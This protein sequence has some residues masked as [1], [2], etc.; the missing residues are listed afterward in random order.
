MRF[1]PKYMSVAAALAALSLGL[2]SPA[3]AAPI[4]FGFDSD[5]TLNLDGGNDE[6]FEEVAA[7]DWKVGNALAL[8]GNTAIHTFLATGGAVKTPFDVFYQASLAA[9]LDENGDPL[10]TSVTTGLNQLTIVAGFTEQVRSFNGTPGTAGA[11][12]SFELAAAQNVNY[13]QIYWDDTTDASDLHG[14]GFNNTTDT[15]DGTALPPGSTV[16]TA[17]PGAGHAVTSVVDPNARLILDA[18]IDQIFSSVFEVST[19][20][21]TNLDSF[22]TDN[23]PG[24]DSVVGSGATTLSA[25]LNFFDPTFFDFGVHPTNLLMTLFNSSQI[26]PFNGTNPSAR[27]LTGSTTTAAGSTPV[28]D[29]A[30]LNLGEGLGSV[31][32]G[33]INGGQIG[34]GGGPDIQFQVDGSSS[35]AVVP[36]PGS[37]VLLSL[38]ALGLGLARTRRRKSATA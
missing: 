30:G 13:L 12:A 6:G 25:S 27:F 18:T 5:S 22:G 36:E 11:S 4:T 29:G 33:T 9:L 16:Y 2:S 24:I 15:S 37:L 14:T 20:P 23:F 8:E 31:S 17:P 32:L 1:L 38:G 26:L 21:I 19:A 34:A 10:F 35:F 28:L 3:H 7:F